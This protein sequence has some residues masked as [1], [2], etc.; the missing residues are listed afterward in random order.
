MACRPLNTKWIP[1]S[2]LT[3]HDLIP[4]FECIINRRIK[5]PVVSRLRPIGRI[6]LFSHHATPLSSLCKSSWMYWTSKMFVRYI[7]S[8]VCPRLRPLPRL[9]FMRYMVLCVYNLP[10][11]LM[12]IVT[13]RV[14][15]LII[16]NKSERWQ[17]CHCV[18]LGH[19]T[20]VCAAYLSVFLWILILIMEC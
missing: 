20:I 2:I 19:E 18:G 8:C 14:F 7:L 10:I 5:V 16:I 15:Y 12:V 4:P 13:I 3:M 17:S 6:R 1:E 9:S 11:S